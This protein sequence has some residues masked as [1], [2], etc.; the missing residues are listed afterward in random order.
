MG[1]V[2]EEL[3]LNCILKDEVKGEGEGG[4]TAGF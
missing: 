3:T 1:A 4:E 2:S